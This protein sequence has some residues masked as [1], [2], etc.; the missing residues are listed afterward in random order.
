MLK[1][2][3][4]QNGFTLV[5]ALVALLVLSI[6]MLGIAA[7]YVESLRAGRTALL[8]TSAVNLA[9][10]MA[11]RIRA[12]RA[13]GLA[14]EGAAGVLCNPG[15]GFAAPADQ[16][17]NEVACWQDTVAASLPNGI[18]TVDVDDATIPTTYTITVSWGEVGQAVA[19]SYV[20]RLQT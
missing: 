16:A 7:L 11:D 12:N 6:G 9:A 15:L 3:R 17:L 5:E 10:D 8:R 20:M 1:H 2:G 18:G 19:A 13:G 4:Q 14:Y